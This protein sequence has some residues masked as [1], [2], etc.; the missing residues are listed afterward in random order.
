[1][2]FLHERIKNGPF[3]EGKGLIINS[4]WCN[5]NTTQF[6]TLS[7]GIITTKPLSQ[8]FLT[9]IILPVLTIEPK[10]YQNRFPKSQNYFYPNRISKNNWDQVLSKQ[11]SKNNQNQK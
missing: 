4:T 6:T 2:L 10:F 9:K 1:M 8:T 11:I 3:N 7:K 5:Y